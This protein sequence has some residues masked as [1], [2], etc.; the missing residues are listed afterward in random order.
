MLVLSLSS[1]E[2][3]A[4]PIARKRST[5]V[6]SPSGGSG[7][8]LKSPVCTIVP[9]TVPIASALASTI[10]C[11]TRTGSTSNGPA[12]KRSPAATARKSSER[13]EKSCSA[14]RRR[15]KPSACGGPHT[16]TSSS[17]SRYGNAPM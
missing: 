8:M 17:P 4:S 9:A 12:W 11:A 2:T 16:G 14:S 7:S 6:G 10:E 1:S 5:F 3:P 13:L 15:A